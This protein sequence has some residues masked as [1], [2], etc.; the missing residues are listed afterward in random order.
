[1]T[2]GR[3]MNVERRCSA[4][5]PG[6]RAQPPKRPVT[7]LER[8]EGGAIAAA[9]VMLFILAGFAWWWLL[10][11]FVAFDL[12]MIGFIGGNRT[13]AIVYNSVHN[14]A[15]PAALASLYVILLLLGVAVWPLAFVAGC[16]F[17]HVA[18]DRALGQGPR[19]L[20]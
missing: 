18:V 7:L 2:L 3:N 14:Y 10:A 1:M 19:P 8:I 13:G 16:W 11:V 5:A 17:F 12:S 4:I 6:D 15:A 20:A 9:T